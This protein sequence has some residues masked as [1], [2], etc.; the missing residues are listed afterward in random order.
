MQR[1][2]HIDSQHVSPTLKKQIPLAIME[3]QNEN[4]ET[5]EL[6]WTLFNKVFKV[7]AGDDTVTFNPK[8]WCT[9]MAG[10]NMN[11]LGKVFGEDVLTRIKSCEFHFK[12]SRN[13]TAKKLNDADGE[14]FKEICNEMLE[15]SLEEAYQSA[16]RNLEQFIEE[17]PER[18]FLHS[19]LD[20][21]DGRKVFIFHAFAPTIAPKMNL[22]EVIHAGWSNRDA[23]NLTLLDAA[24]TDAKDSILLA[25]ELKVIEKGSL[26]VFGPSFQEKNERLHHQELAR[27][28]KL[29]KDIVALSDFQV[30]PNSG[31]R[32]PVGKK[33]SQST[34]EVPRNK[35]RKGPL[36]SHPSQHYIKLQQCKH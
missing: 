25:A 31:H 12:E 22:A 24:Q 2:R 35:L 9:D 5:I 4:S 16:K 19:W 20:W 34:K 26:T 11:G 10:A 28:R 33:S 3:T 8:G 14:L 1:L 13:R 7:V 32:P 23:P 36:S 30:D 18:K 17:A 29:G 27:A 6:F 21:W 15:S